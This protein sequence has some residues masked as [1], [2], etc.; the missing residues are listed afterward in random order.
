MNTN[1]CVIARLTVSLLFLSFSTQ[2]FAFYNPTAGRWLSRDP[3]EEF[4]G[5][6]LNSFRGNDLVARVDGLG[7]DINVVSIATCDF[8]AGGPLIGP[9]T[10]TLKAWRWHVWGRSWQDNQIQ[11]FFPGTDIPI[12]PR[13]HIPTSGGYWIIFGGWV[14]VDAK[15]GIPKNAWTLRS[16]IVTG[17]PS[18]GPQMQPAVKCIYTCNF[19]STIM[20]TLPGSGSMSAPPPVQREDGT[21][22]E[23]GPPPVYW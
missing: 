1:A 19:N 7:L 6:N 13:Y 8:C 9:T 16:F 5:F 22:E 23:G 18:I 12:T 20:A 2:A 3:I 10:A 11:I 14:V 4:G 15:C 17:W 21:S